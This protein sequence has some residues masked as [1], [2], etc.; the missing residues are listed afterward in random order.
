MSRR[1]PRGI[2]A[3]LVGLA[4]PALRF[5]FDGAWFSAALVSAVV[6]SCSCGAATVACRLRR[7]LA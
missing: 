6:Y 2:V 5:L 3:A 4:V 7:R 1:W